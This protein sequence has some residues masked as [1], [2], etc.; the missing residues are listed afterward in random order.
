[1]GTYHF[2][3][4]GIILILLIYTLIQNYKLQEK[5]KNNKIAFIQ[6]LEKIAE[7]DARIEFLENSK[8]LEK[9][10]LGQFVSRN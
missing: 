2:I 8:R 3:Q 9:T 4:T 10:V 6:L 1:M 5:Q 7:L